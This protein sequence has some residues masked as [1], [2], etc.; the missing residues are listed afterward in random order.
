M[1]Q[2][3]RAGILAV[4]LLLAGCTGGGSNPPSHGTPTSGGGGYTVRPAFTVPLHNLQ[5]S[6]HAR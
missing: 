1:R 4:A 6:Q 2:R 5:H 3:V